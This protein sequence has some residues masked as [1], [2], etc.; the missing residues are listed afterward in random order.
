MPLASRGAD[1]VGV[2]LRNSGEK[3]LAHVLSSPLP[4]QPLEAKGVLVAV[5][6]LVPP[7]SPPAVA[8]GDGVRD[9]RGRG[10]GRHGGELR[11]P[12]PNVPSRA[13]LHEGGE[14]AYD[15]VAY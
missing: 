1:Y 5:A 3:S 13:G 4:P 7:P 15:V 6:C 12:A 8:L 2:H 14:G 9:P 11:G 10:R